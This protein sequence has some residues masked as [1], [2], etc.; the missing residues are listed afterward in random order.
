MGRA[1][2]RGNIERRGGC[3][4]VIMADSRVITGDYVMGYV[5]LTSI[6]VK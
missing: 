5:W 2:E 4:G 3:K 6:E 1:N